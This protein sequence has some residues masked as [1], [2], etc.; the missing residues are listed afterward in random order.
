VSETLTTDLE[1]GAYVLVC[2]HLRRGRE[3]SSLPGGDADIPHCGLKLGRYRNTDYITQAI[4]VGR[5]L[6]L[7]EAGVVLGY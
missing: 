6:G 7:L 5:L 3:G 4:R 2:K 1:A